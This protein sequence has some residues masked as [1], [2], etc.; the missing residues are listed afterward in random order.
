MPEA[1]NI[2]RSTRDNIFI[3][4]RLVCNAAPKSHFRVSFLGPV[5]LATVIGQDPQERDSGV[6]ISMHKLCCWVPSGTMSVQEWRKQDWTE[7]ELN[8]K[9]GKASAGPLNWGK[10]IGLCMF[11]C[12]CFWMWVVPREAWPWTRHLPSAKVSYLWRNSGPWP[13]PAANTPR[14][15]GNKFLGTERGDLGLAQ[16]PAH[17]STCTCIA[18]LAPYLLH[19]GQTPSHLSLHHWTLTPVWLCTSP[20]LMPGLPNPSRE[21]SRD[22]IHNLH[23]QTLL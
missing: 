2:S 6:E 9:A 13:L 3:A 20:D 12:A 23:Q 8:G 7:G 21:F 15:W 11:T 10:G 17:S 4:S 5:L 16:H 1:F 18:L 14:S 22:S 19:K